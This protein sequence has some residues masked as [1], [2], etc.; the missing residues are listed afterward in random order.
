MTSSRPSQTFSSAL[1]IQAEAELLRRSLPEFVRKAWPV[2]EPAPFAGGFHIDAICEHL[3]AVAAGEIQRLVINVP[4]RHGKSLLVCVFFPAWL[5]A[6]RPE[7]RWLYASYAQELAT[8]DSVRTRRLI[9]SPW[10]R[11]RFGHV[12]ALTGDQNAKDRYENNRTGVRLATGV[13]GAAT[14]E[15]GD[16]I[17]IDDAHKIE[18]ATSTLTR[19]STVDW[20]DTT[21]S[22]RLNHPATGAIVVIGQRLHQRDLPGHLLAQGDWEHLCL[23]AEYEPDHPFLWPEDPRSEP[24]ELL[25]PER[26]GPSEIARL[27]RSMGSVAAAGQL[28]QRPAPAGGAVFERHWW[29]FYPPDQA[30]AQFDRIVQSWDLALSGTPGSDYVVGQTWGAVGPRKYLLRQTRRRLS[31]TETIAAIEEMTA[32]VNTHFPGEGGHAILVEHAANGAA[33]VDV[34]RRRLPGVIPVIPRGDK[35]T[36]AQAVTPQVEAGDVYLPGYPDPRGNG[37]DRT[38]TPDWVQALVHETATFPHGANDDQVDALS[39]A[40]ARLSRP[41]VRIRFL[42]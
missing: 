31:F 38:L 23:P 41:G 21:M 36:R 22:T 17:V 32:W 20:F 13:G 42:G 12:F 34:L 24:G 6:S 15:G 27:K 25:W 35:L 5:W 19:E 14:G 28:Q 11:E 1:A 18:E 10:Y 26:F 9:E 16:I 7:V 37:P 3:E 2:V 33:A 8:R 40:L 29:R 30:P 4:P 39:Q